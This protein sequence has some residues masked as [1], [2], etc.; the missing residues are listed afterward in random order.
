MLVVA[1]LT[2][3]QA[4]A[5]L[6]LE[7]TRPGDPEWLLSLIAP[8]DPVAYANT[9][10]GLGVPLAIA[11]HFAL[12][13]ISVGLAVLGTRRPRARRI[14]MVAFMSILAFTVGWQV[15]TLLAVVGFNNTFGD[16]GGW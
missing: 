16:T 9:T 11:A 4:T 2:V 10:L 5:A 14:A 12:A 8:A 3:V 6:V 13:P 7:L 15:Y 1:A